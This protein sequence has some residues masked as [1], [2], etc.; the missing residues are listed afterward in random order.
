MASLNTVHGKILVGEKIDEFGKSNFSSPIFTDM[1]NVYSICTDCCL[2][3]KILLPI[4]FTYLVS[5][6]FPLPNIYQVQ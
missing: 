6:N 5:Q 3:A 1:E 4:A 2:F